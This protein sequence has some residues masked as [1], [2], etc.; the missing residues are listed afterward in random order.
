[1]LVPSSLESERL[2]LEPLK[3]D[4]ADE[5]VN[6]LDDPALHR[7]TGGAPA[8]GLA[9]LR[10]RFERQA[11]GESPDGRDGWL[12]WVLRERASGR[13]VGTVQATVTGRTDGKVAEL[14]WVIGTGA[15]GNGFGKE[16]AATVADWLRAQGVVRL[17]AHIH[18]QHYESM[19]V[20]RS[21][22]L[23]ATPV[24]VDGETRWEWP[25]N[26]GAA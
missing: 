8:A 2:V 18:P 24:I 21:A 19:A 14:A 22:G 20:A 5:L 23:K 3:P 11:R 15:Q 17:R 16:A 25:A 12:N 9:E 6:V 7:F 13:P 1:M 10:A 26:A 4:H